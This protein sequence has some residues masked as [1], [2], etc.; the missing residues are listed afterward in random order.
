MFIFGRIWI[1]LLGFIFLE[2]IDKGNWRVIALLNSI[3][4]FICLLGSIMYIEESARFLI[5]SG[6]I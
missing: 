4:C 3:P 1:V 2:T 6:K 5:C